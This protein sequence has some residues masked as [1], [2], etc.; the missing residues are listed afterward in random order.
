MRNEVQVIMFSLSA[1]G[2]N[3]LDILA[4]NAAS[5]AI[6]I[7]DIPWGGPVAAVR[8][9]RVPMSGFKYSGGA[10]TIDQDTRYPWDGAVKMTVKPQRS[11]RPW[12]H[13]CRWASAAS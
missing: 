8:V 3:P 5:A 4:I 11:R 6:M 13:A 9:G 7:S 10:V 1:D 2:V 12:R